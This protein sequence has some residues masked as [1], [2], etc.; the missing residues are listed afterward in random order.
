MRKTTKI[1]ATVVAIALVLTGMLIAIYAATLGGATIN[2][3]V[4]WVAQ[5]G[6]DLEFWAV[7]SGGDEVKT[8]TQRRIKPETTNQDATIVG[9]LSCNFKDYTDDGVNNPENISFKYYIK[10][11]KLSPL[12]VQLIKSPVNANESGTN[13]SDHTPKVEVSTKAD[14]KSVSLVLGSAEG[15][16]L[17]AGETLEYSVVLSMETGGVGSINADTSINTPFNASVEFKFGVGEVTNG[18]IVAQIENNTPVTVQ[19]SAVAGQTLGE[20]LSTIEPEISTGWFFDENLTK[21]V[22]DDY[23]KLELNSMSNAKFYC[24]NASYDG[25]T[26]SLNGDNKSYSVK[27]DGTDLAT[28]VIPSKYDGLPVTIISDSAFKDSAYLCTV[29]FPSSITTIGE[30]AFNNCTSIASII[31]PNSIK[32]I[33]LCAFGGCTGLSH[34]AIDDGVTALTDGFEFFS[35][36]NLRIFVP[37]TV[38]VISGISGFS[39]ENIKIYTDLLTKPSGWN[40]G[41]TGLREE[42]IIFGYT[43]AQFDALN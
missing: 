5:Q 7:V 39:A 16:N 32:R 26:F 34:F 9:D 41:M 38:S 36:N 27:S 3:N 28:I 1:I 14:D 22:T 24:K 33:K 18:S 2:A 6:V 40:T 23:L 8:I 15:Y 11:Y 10:N 20:Y 25:L 17:G 21:A 35:C 30:F 37:F 12:N 4:S 42:N 31:L 43:R 29:T 13:A 19:S